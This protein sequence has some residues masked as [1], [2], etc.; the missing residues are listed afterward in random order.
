MYSVIYAKIKTVSYNNILFKYFIIFLL[1]LQGILSLYQGGVGGFWN[2]SE[3]NRSSANAV[4][5][6]LEWSLTC[7]IIMG[8]YSMSIDVNHF[9]FVYENRT[10][11][12][13]EKEEIYVVD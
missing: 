8:F 12:S 11:V 5:I 1:A 2:L 4:D 7:T 9:E 13:Q 6:C 10:M 3:E